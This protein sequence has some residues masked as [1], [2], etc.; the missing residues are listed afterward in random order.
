MSE[1]EI[2]NFALLGFGAVIFVTGF[3]S[4]LYTNRYRSKVS[5]NH[6]EAE[7]QKKLTSK[8]SSTQYH[9]LNNIT[10][11]IE[12]GTTQID[13]I[14]VSTRGVFVIETKHYSGWIF[15]DPNSKQWMQ[16][17]YQVKTRFQN[18]IHQNYLHVKAIQKLLDFLPGDQIHSVVV[19]TGSAEFKTPMPKNVFYLEQLVEHLQAFQEDAISAN[20]VEFCVG[21][22]EC[23]RY[24]LTG[25][26][27]VRHQAYL[28]KKYGE[29]AD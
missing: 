8:F 24:E 15:G 16:V 18:P 22:I 5:Q 20:R 27:D 6:G 4:G 1:L 17:I 28:D 19:F 11:P 25:L 12:D 26:T 14:L 7:V 2:L 23:K 13:H 29:F 10:I 21:R 3:L 9:L